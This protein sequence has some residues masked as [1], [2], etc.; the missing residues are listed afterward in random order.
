M[1]RYYRTRSAVHSLG[2]KK[3]IAVLGVM[4]LLALALPFEFS[5]LT[6]PLG[7]AALAASRIPLREA[8]WKSLFFVGAFVFVVRALFDA[9]SFA[10]AGLTLTRG[11]YYGV[12]NA[13][14]LTGMLLLAEVAIKT[15]KPSAFAS[16]LR[17]LG[18]GKR[19]S[20]M[21]SIALQAVPLFQGKIKRV[22]IAQKARGSRSRVFP[23]VVP[24]M[25]S[26]FQ[27]A[28]KMSIALEARGFDPEKL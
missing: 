23:L 9:Q 18:L 26:L 11:V 25:H 14:Y 6:F 20:M 7:L 4:A 2:A 21:F 17:E 27:R 22:E 8:G 3:K 16:A 10:W 13:L 1:I 15:T 28:R 24:V 12:L 19:R 5:A